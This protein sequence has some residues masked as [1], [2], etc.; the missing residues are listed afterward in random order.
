MSSGI[1]DLIAMPS[2]SHTPSPLTTARADAGA[3]N[4]PAPTAPA[5]PAA[6]SGATADQPLRR[7]GAPRNPHRRGPLPPQARRK[8]VAIRE[9]ADDAHGAWRVADD[10]WREA[11]AKRDE[12][13]AR[14]VE[15]Q[16]PRYAGRYGGPDFIPD[17]G[18]DWTDPDRGP[19]I[20]INRQLLVSPEDLARAVDDVAAAD[21]EVKRLAEIAEARSETWRALAATRE[22]VERFLESLPAGAVLRSHPAPVVSTKGQAAEQELA[23]VREA[24][25]T[26]AADLHQVRS[27]QLPAAEAK[28]V[29]RAYV[30]ELAV[31]G[32]PTSH[33]LLDGVHPE[34][35][36]VSSHHVVETNAGGV[37]T[38]S[39]ASYDLPAILAWL[40][41]EAMVAALE[42]DVNQLA[43]DTT[44][45]SRKDRV[46]KEA[47]LLAVQLET[48]RL[49]EALVMAMGT[50]ERRA[51]DP[52]AVLEIDGPALREA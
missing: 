39:T 28:D 15:L 52:R 45:L 29:A 19:P 9:A 38:V 27:A 26:H 37:G 41:P 13:Q 21:A 33:Y 43:D 36:N 10:R 4:I 34:W 17:G 32:A 30:D 31:R 22:A 44:A 24:I 5:T 11:K 6:A 2:R 16:D 42:R 1:G 3:G 35:P 48:E 50:N 12:L 18:R 46:A 47:E 14:L 23:R 7:P 40:N 20:V 51:A 25:G 8:L 49:E